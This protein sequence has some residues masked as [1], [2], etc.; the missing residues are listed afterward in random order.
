MSVKAIFRAQHLH[1]FC[2]KSHKEK[3]S[4]LPLRSNL[5][6][7]RRLRKRTIVRHHSRRKYPGEEKNEL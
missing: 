1:W 2:I 3:S 7:L 4:E 5:R 6:H